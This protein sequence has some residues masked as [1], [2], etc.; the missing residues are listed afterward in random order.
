MC[1]EGTRLGKKLGNKSQ[2]V[3]NFSLQTVAYMLITVV[4]FRQRCDITRPMFDEDRVPMSDNV[5]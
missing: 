3:L 4:T 2:R 1:S 5:K